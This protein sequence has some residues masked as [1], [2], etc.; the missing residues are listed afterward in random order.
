[1]FNKI[2]LF[3]HKNSLHRFSSMNSN[4]DSLH[5]SSQNVSISSFTDDQ[6]D[7]NKAIPTDDYNDTVL[8]RDDLLA[9]PKTP[10]KMNNTSTP[11]IVLSDQKSF[12]KG[13]ANQQTPIQNRLDF[14][15]STVTSYTPKTANKTTFGN[16]SI[17][18]T[19][20]SRYLTPCSSLAFQ[21]LD[22]N[23]TGK[24]LNASFG[25]V[26]APSTPTSSNRSK[27]STY[28]IDLTTP[29]IFHTPSA[30]TSASVSIRSKTLLKSALKNSSQSTAGTTPRK[31]ILGSTIK[32]HKLYNILNESAGDTT[33]SMH[34]TN[35]TSTAI[36]S[37]LAP[38]KN[39]IASPAVTVLNVTPKMKTP[40]KTAGSAKT[41]RIN[42][43]P[44]NQYSSP[45]ARQSVKI[46]KTP[47][48]KG[49]IKKANVSLKGMC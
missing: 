1:M 30:G 13:D 33:P 47:V 31:S 4:D 32:G 7:E 5:S 38:A 20:K 29:D 3:L 36:A 11:L 19:P 48:P 34:R 6:D 24:T 42:T 16:K 8:G 40:Y 12:I 25:T 18:N 43:T 21:T 26:R 45:Y 23:D 35:V 2:V 22:Y 44:S 39:V 27:I 37:K 17:T 28:L 15:H 14:S 49:S 46:A 10:L 9:S 41:V